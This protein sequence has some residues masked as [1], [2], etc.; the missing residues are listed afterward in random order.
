MHFVGWL[1]VVNWLYTM[2]GAKIIRCAENSSIRNVSGFDSVKLLMN[3][4]QTQ[5]VIV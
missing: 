4:R 1:S 5:K 3:S 2:R